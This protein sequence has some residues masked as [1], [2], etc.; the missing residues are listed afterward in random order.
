M[1][2]LCV[3]EKAVREIGCVCFI[4]AINGT[5]TH[6][7]FFPLSFNVIIATAMTSPCCLYTWLWIIG[8]FLAS[9]LSCTVQF[10]FCSIC[11]SLLNKKKMHLWATA[12][13]RFVIFVFLFSLKAWLL[14][15]Q[16]IS[17]SLLYAL[18]PFSDFVYA[19]SV[20]SSCSSDYIDNTAQS[21]C[22]KAHVFVCVQADGRKL[23]QISI[24]MHW[25]LE[26]S[27]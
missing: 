12:L 7:H 27:D 16:E 14:T 18:A 8:L 6:A 9:V 26:C 4:M 1:Q 13:Q 24:L 23:L 22:H 3:L 5:H 10:F 17:W 25:S 21:I 20:V 19:V 15:L 2:S 11:V